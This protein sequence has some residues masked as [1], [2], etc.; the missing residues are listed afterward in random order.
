MNLEI[1]DERENSTKK[2][3]LEGNTLKDRLASLELNPETVL[4]ARNNEI[5]TDDEVLHDKDRLEILSV[6]SGG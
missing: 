5:L 3:S 6:I 4:V 1:F 2:V